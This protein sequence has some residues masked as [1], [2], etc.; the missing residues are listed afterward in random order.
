M[1]GVFDS[2]GLTALLAIATTVVPAAAVQFSAGACSYF[3]SSVQVPGVN[4]CR[5]ALTRTTVHDVTSTQTSTISQGVTTVTDWVATVTTSSTAVVGA[6]T[7]TKETYRYTALRKYTVTTTTTTTSV[8]TTSVSTTLSTATVATTTSRAI[9]LSTTI[10]TAAVAATASGLGVNAAAGAGT[11]STT[12]TTPSAIIGGTAR[13]GAST[14]TTT[15]AAAA[16]ATNA[17]AAAGSGSSTT[18]T[19]TTTVAP[20][21]ATNASAASGAGSSTTKTTTTTVAPAVATNASAGVGS[22]TTMTTVAAVA[23]VSVNAGAVAST[24]TTATT[25]TT[26]VVLATVTMNAGSGTSRSS[27]TTITMNPYDD[28]TVMRKRDIACPVTV[29]DQTLWYLYSTSTTVPATTAHQSATTTVTK[30]TTSTDPNGYQTV[31]GEIRGTTT[32]TSTISMTTT[33]TSCGACATPTPFQII[34]P[35]NNARVVVSPSDGSLVAVPATQDGQWTNVRLDTSGHLTYTDASGTIY[36]AYLGHDADN[37][38]DPLSSSGWKQIYFQPWGKWPQIT[39]LVCTA[40]GQGADINCLVAGE[41][42][43]FFTPGYTNGP[44]RAEFI[45]R[46]TASTLGRGYRPVAWIVWS[47]H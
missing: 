21:V 2:V 4:T 10:T 11:T 35:A 27:S 26:D 12:T 31:Y 32:V 34:A 33:T 47:A 36:Q 37:S 14:T 44:W 29:C 16:V 39:A 41:Q 6:K 19:T 15:T 20:A 40:T 13:S 43:G 18:K 28:P 8:S 23:T 38:G 30:V 5:G 46:L 22:S 17:G 7:V 24:A 25:T 9:T 3:T 1:K 45:D 42:I